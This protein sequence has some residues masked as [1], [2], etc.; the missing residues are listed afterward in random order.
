M[1]ALDGGEFEDVKHERVTTRR[2]QT[3]CSLYY[4]NNV[5][6]EGAGHSS[7]E[8]CLV[9]EVIQEGAISK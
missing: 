6:I 4:P 3:K 8:I 9:N 5:E 2:I 7:N 1:I